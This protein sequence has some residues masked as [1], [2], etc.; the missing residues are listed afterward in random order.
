MRLITGRQ[1]L[2]DEWR[3]LSLVLL[4]DA[5]T[6]LEKT[7]AKNKTKIALVCTALVRLAL[8]FQKNKH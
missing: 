7:A 4:C 8:T 3:S 5:D 1:V 2:F 6:Y